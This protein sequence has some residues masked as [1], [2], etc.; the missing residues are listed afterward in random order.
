MVPKRT[1]FV[2]S[3]RRAL[4][5]GGVEGEKKGMTGQGGGGRKKD[6]QLMGGE[7]LYRRN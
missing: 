3:F 6:E 1:M 7:G 2:V 5:R 4:G